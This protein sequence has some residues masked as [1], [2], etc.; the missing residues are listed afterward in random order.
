MHLT[1]LVAIFQQLLCIKKKWK[2]K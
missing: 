2:L 1:F